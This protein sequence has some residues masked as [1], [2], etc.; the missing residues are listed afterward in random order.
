MK[1]ILVNTLRGLLH[2]EGLPLHMCSD[3]RKF[4]H[5]GG[6]STFRIDPLLLDTYP[7]DTFTWLVKGMHYQLL[8]DS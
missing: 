2:F 7:R 8:G 4:A 5:A 1:N 6:A 3:V